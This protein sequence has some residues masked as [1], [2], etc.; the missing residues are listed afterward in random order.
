LINSMSSKFIAIPSIYQNLSPPTASRKQIV[1]KSLYHLRAM[2]CSHFSYPS[3]STQDAI[4]VL[5][6]IVVC[7]RR[8]W[9]TISLYCNE[10]GVSAHR[11]IRKICDSLPLSKNEETM[12]LSRNSK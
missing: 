4:H 10:N 6:P 5:S 2:H 9:K 1:A 7:L 8:K 11:C 12:L 3:P